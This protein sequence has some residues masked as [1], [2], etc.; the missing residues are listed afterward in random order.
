MLH[1]RFM[2]YAIFR[3][4]T[5]SAIANLD[6]SPC[7]STIIRHYELHTRY[8]FAGQTV[9][10]LFYSVYFLHPIIS[11]IE[12]E[13]SYIEWNLRLFLDDDRTGHRRTTDIKTN[14]QKKHDRQETLIFQPAFSHI[15]YQS[16]APCSTRRYIAAQYPEL[17][18]TLRCRSASRRQRI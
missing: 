14:G 10:Q 15:T 2:L 1:P 11:I 5:Y 13:T 3:I 4:Q 18:G 17:L 12:S 9:F 6:R 7:D 8:L 16:I